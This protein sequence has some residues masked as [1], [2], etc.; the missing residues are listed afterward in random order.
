MV[1]ELAHWEIC[2]QRYTEPQLCGVWDG[3]L[4]PELSEPIV[5]VVGRDE[6]ESEGVGGGE[7]RGGGHLDYESVSSAK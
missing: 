1:V 5:W 7:G 6:G 3:P 2:W 4:G